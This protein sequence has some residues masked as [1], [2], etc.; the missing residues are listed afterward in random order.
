VHGVEIHSGDILVSRG[1]YPTR[2]S[3]ARGNDYPGN[4]LALGLVHVDGVSHAASVIERTSSAV[5]AVSTATRTCGT[6]SSGSW[7]CACGRTCALVADPS[8]ATP[9]RVAGLERARSG[10]VAYDFEMEYTD[11][12]EALLLG[13]GLVGPMASWA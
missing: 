8:A 11:P 4:F 5:V 2:R 10:R 13:G 9:G 1:G 7:C 12:S 6:R 3:F